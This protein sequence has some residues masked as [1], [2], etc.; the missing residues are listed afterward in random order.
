MPQSIY[1]FISFSPLSLPLP[2]FPPQN[3]KPKKPDKCKTQVGEKKKKK[4]DLDPRTHRLELDAIGFDLRPREGVAGF[5]FEVVVC[6]G[7]DPAV[8]PAFVERGEG[9]VE[10]HRC[11][12]DV[13]CS[14]GGG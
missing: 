6:E 14:G 9:F 3:Q 10:V 12:V 13:C 1:T 8:V 4:T 5:A 11:I 7:G 2:F